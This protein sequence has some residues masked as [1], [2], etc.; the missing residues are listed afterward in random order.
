MLLGSAQDGGGVD[1]RAAINTDRSL[2]ATTI[3][4]RDPA[5]VG[6][7]GILALDL[8]HYAVPAPIASEGKYWSS[9]FDLDLDFLRTLFCAS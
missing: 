4:N 5:V 9:G 3:S 6:I 8:P 7:G 1:G 2:V